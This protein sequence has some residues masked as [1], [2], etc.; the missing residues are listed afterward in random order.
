M[1]PLICDNGS[2]C[3]ARLA[4]LIVL[5]PFQRFYSLG[6]SGSAFVWSKKA[7]AFSINTVEH[8]HKFFFSNVLIGHFAGIVLNIWRW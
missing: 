4:L 2:E 3:T 7:V 6:S 1:N 5:Y 8:F